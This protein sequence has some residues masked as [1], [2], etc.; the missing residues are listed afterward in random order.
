MGRRRRRRIP[1]TCTTGPP[2]PRGSGRASARP[3]MPAHRFPPPLSPLASPP[4]RRCSPTC[5][6]RP[7]PRRRQ[8]RPRRHRRGRHRA[9]VQTRNLPTRAGPSS[10]H[11]PCPSAHHRR[12]PRRRPPDP[13]R[14]V[15]A[16]HRWAPDGTP[17]TAGSSTPT[18]RIRCPPGPSGSTASATCCPSPAS[19]DR[20]RCGPNMSGPPGVNR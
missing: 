4:T 11:P 9:P 12:C 14:R 17:D 3:P 8:G 16:H 5:R 18:V 10:A 1:M 20:R 2:I 19:T 13:R 6:N 15:P 7:P